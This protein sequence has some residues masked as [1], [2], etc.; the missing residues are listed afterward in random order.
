[1][2]MFLLLARVSPTLLQRMSTLVMGYAVWSMDE[3]QGKDF[4]LVPSSV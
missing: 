1:M 3:R 4:A 2:C